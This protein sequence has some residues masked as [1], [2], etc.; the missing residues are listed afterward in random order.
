MLI[1]PLF[2]ILYITI[3]FYGL[4][5]YSGSNQNPEGLQLLS[6]NSSYERKHK[7]ADKA[8]IERITNSNFPS[9]KI[10]DYTKGGAAFTGDFIDVLEIKFEKSISSEFIHEL[11]SLSSIDNSGWIKKN[12]GYRFSMMWGNEMPAPKG[13]SDDEDWFISIDIVKEQQEATIKY[14]MW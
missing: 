9:F 13:E 14:G 3:G 1:S 5:G 10:V 6:I 4:T 2:L 8:T 12:T 11:D 7:F